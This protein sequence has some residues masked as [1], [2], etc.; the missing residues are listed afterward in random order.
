MFF[1]RGHV[2]LHKDTQK[3]NGVA[4]ITLGLDLD[5]FSCVE[6]KPKKRTHY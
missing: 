5:L 3:W 2:L 1:K 4:Q 6:S